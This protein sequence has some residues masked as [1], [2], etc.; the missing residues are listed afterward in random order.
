MTVQDEYGDYYNEETG[1]F[2]REYSEIAVKVGET[3]TISDI[4]YGTYTSQCYYL[5]E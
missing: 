2:D 5:P 3:R 4:P 1:V